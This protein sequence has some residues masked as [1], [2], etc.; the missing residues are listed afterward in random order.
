MDENEML[1]VYDEI[2]GDYLKI[3]SNDKKILISTGLRQVPYNM[4]K[5]YYHV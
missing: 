5:F 1:E 3:S 4:T 2:I